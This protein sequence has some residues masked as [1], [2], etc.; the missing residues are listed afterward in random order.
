MA[1][2][3]LTAAVPDGDLAEGAAIVAA[4]RLGQDAE[5]RGGHQL[6]SFALALDPDN[7]RALLLQARHERGQPF[8]E[9][10]L[11]DSGRQFV[12]FLEEA[13]A[14]ATPKTRALLLYRVIELVDPDHERAL[15]ELTRAKNQGTDTEFETLLDA[16][17]AK[18]SAK[19]PAE[20][21]KKTGEKPRDLTAVL[22]RVTYQ[23][24]S[25]PSHM[26]YAEPMF[27]L[28]ELNRLLRASGISIDV[29]SKTR[30]VVKYNNGQEM[31]SGAFRSRQFRTLGYYSADKDPLAGAS[32]QHIVW[33]MCALHDLGWQPDGNRLLL[34]D[35][36]DA[37]GP[38][39]GTLSDARSLTEKVEKSHTGFLK[40]Y[41]GKDIY[42]MGVVSGLG[43]GSA[44]YVH[45]AGDQVRVYLDSKVSAEAVA[46][47]TDNYDRVVKADRAS[48]RQTT[49]TNTTGTTE[50]AVLFVG[51]ARCDGVISGRVVLKGCGDFVSLRTSLA[52]SN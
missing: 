16:I 17:Q 5:D 28:N 23:P 49:T 2:V 10:Q 30:P 47:L 24:T 41:K 45:L 6:L 4:C 14:K 33:L 42:V 1:S 35:A 25:A 40:A 12:T 50:R 43:K 19:P 48:R 36:A 51:E 13:A 8:E 21:P 29:Q 20:E 7:E 26:L 37:S 22:A 38:G 39:S 52:Q 11:A 44:R 18:E 15:L 46:K 9:M 27:V 32:G 31:Q 34:V 3:C